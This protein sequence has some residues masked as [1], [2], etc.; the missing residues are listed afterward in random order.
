MKLEFKGSSQVE[1]YFV[2]KELQEIDVQIRC[3]KTIPYE[4]K[5]TL[6]MPNPNDLKTKLLIEWYTFGYYCYEIEC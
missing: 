2:L 6:V 3:S 1:T 4:Y 5:V